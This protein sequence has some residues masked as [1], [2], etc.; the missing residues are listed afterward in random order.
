ME[1]NQRKQLLMDKCYEKGVKDTLK[2]VKEII[3]KIEKHSVF[4]YPKNSKKR[5]IT[6]SMSEKVWNKEFKGEKSV[7]IMKV[8][9]DV[10]R[11]GE[12]K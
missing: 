9:F 2:R 11:K 1:V 10:K 12:K 5:I 4:T 3:N 8:K 7:G 6:F